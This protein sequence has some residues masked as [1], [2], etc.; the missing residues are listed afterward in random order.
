MLLVIIDYFS[1][2]FVSFPGVMGKFINP[3]WRIQDGR[4]LRIMTKLPR[5]MTSS[6]RVADHIGDIFVL[7]III[8]IIMIVY[9]TFLQHKLNYKA[10]H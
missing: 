3:R 10:G 7:T 6:V 5:Q 9:S 2:N 8:I 4:H 1:F